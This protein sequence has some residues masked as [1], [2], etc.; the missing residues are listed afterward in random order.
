MKDITIPDIHKLVQ[1]LFGSEC[2]ERQQNDVA[3]DGM[4][5]VAKAAILTLTKSLKNDE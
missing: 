5:I 1:A 2:R 4:Q 3:I